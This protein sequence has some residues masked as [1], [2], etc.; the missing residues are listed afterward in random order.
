MAETLYLSLRTADGLSRQAFQ[1]QFG[2]DPEEV[3]PQAFAKLDSRLR[4]VD[5]HWR[6]DLDAWLLYD[7][8]VSNFL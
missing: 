2:S 4:L 7:H 1:Q 6:F 8:L 5:N 3:F